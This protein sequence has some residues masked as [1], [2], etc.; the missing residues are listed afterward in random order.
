[1]YGIVNKAIEELVVAN[2]GQE[3]WDKVKERS[4][5]DIDFFIS[6]EPY[7]DSITYSLAQAVAEEMDMTVGQVLQAFGEWWIL[8]TGR[9]NYGY[10]LA[11]GGDTFEK[12]LI[13]LPLF[14]NRVMMIYPKLTPPEFQ[15]THIL[16][17]SLHLHYYSKREGLQDFVFG[18]ISGLGK[19]YETPVKI[20]LLE[21]RAQG[22]DHEVFYVEWDSEKK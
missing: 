18:L 6:S 21:E 2:F 8:H 1:M 5:I 20:E 13:N 19:F 10:L 17:K 7:D 15:V 11:G 16:E 12:F 3:K 22:S 14:H 4:G 9:K